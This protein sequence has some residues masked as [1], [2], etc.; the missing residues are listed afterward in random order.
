[1][2]AAIDEY[3]ALMKLVELARELKKSLRKKNILKLFQNQ[4]QNTK[5]SKILQSEFG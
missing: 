4:H 5:V 3:G 2:N 1:M